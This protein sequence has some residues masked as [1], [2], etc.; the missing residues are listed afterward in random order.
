MKTKMSLNTRFSILVA[1]I[2]LLSIVVYFGWNSFRDQQS[3]EERV[4]AEAHVLKIEMNAIWDYINE[5]QDRINYNSDGR[6]DFK[7]V[8]CTL[9]GKNIA[10][11][12]MDET[13][14]TIRFVR[15]DPRSRFNEPD[16]F[17][18]SALRQFESG[19][20]TEY[21]RMDTYEGKPVFRYVSML[22]IKGSCL[23]CHGEP[24][25]EKDDTE[26]IKEGMR[27]G[28][29][30]GAISI[31]VPL[32]SYEKAHREDAVV[33]IVF[34]AM[35]IILIV[36]IIQIALRRWVTGP[37]RAL[38]NATSVVGKG[39][40]EIDL[41]DMH[42]R[43]EIK[44]LS[45]D[46]V[47]MARQLKDVYE[48]LEE[49][50]EQRTLSL[51]Q[52]NNNLDEQRRKI[53]E[54]NNSLTI[55]NARLREEGNF[56]TNILAIM[57]HE[58]R[59]P[60]AAIL[61]IVDVWEKSLVNERQEDRKLVDDIKSNCN[62]LLEMIEN[63]IDMAKLEAGR[64]TLS[65]ADVDLVD[66][67][68][69]VDAFVRPLADRKKID[70]ITEVD[71]SIPIVK[72]DWEV[73]RKIVMNLVGNAIKF[74]PDKG[75]VRVSVK[76]ERDALSPEGAQAIVVGVSDTGIG[77]AEEDREKVFTRFTQSDSSVSREYQGSGLGLS[78][79][80]ELTDLLKGRV[81]L[82]SEVGE[83]SEF[84]VILPYYDAYPEH[85]DD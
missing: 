40:F 50:V 4:L 75:S 15:D 37:L 43:G 36:S 68:N 59:T 20:C 17:E 72:S 58:L 69:A 45:D 5:N 38:G 34:F 83:G 85:A 28:D 6:Y 21:Y 18:T 41:A 27:L 49:K 25:G 31:I 51:E 7:G 57:S 10:Y 71:G 19:S 55:A 33:D 56:K 65:M 44:D 29:L 66:V 48:T 22:A 52:A 77:I 39:D 54:V 9:A 23:S 62:S 47:L 11:R 76:C 60:L 81:E 53:E 74:T 73:L 63:T 46:F 1:V 32:D 35:L 30:G 24:A 14:Y 12:F 78:L 64:F 67:I 61:A 3:V 84:R 79:V 70:L 8:Y 42:A 13:D 16:S 2:I 26:Y 80:A 82:E